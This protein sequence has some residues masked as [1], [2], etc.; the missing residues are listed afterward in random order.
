MA[1][2]REGSRGNQVGPELAVQMTK[3]SFIPLSVEEDRSLHIETL[4]TSFSLKLFSS[5]T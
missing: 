4:N 1:V 2:Q 5:A 3:M